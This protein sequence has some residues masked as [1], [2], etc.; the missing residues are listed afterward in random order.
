M[1]T[2][3]PGKNAFQLRRPDVPALCLSVCLFEFL[4]THCVNTSVWRHENT[5]RCASL[6]GERVDAG[7]KAVLQDD[8]KP[9]RQSREFGDSGDFHRVSQNAEGQLKVL[10]LF[11]FLLFVCCRWS[12]KLLLPIW[13]RRRGRWRRW[14]FARRCRGIKNMLHFFLQ[15]HFSH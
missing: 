10:L 3:F 2:R 5:C 9:G 11:L 6:T 12:V 1:F 8:M 13:G 4:V 14:S 7:R 15:I